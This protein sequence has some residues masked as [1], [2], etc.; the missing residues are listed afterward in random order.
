MRWMLITLTSLTPAAAF[1]Q[2]YYIAPAPVPAPTVYYVAP[3]PN[4][5]YVAPTQYYTP[6][7]S[8][9]PKTQIER[10]YFLSDRD[11][12]KPPTARYQSPKS[13]SRT[14]IREYYYVSPNSDLD[15]LEKEPLQELGPPE[16]LQKPEPQ[17]AIG[18]DAVVPEA[19]KS[20]PE[21]AIP[22][23]N[24]TEKPAE[25]KL[26]E[27]K[28]ADEKPAEAKAAEKPAEN[29]PIPESP[30]ET[31]PDGQDGSN[32]PSE[33]TTEEPAPEPAEPA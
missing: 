8:S 15:A 7:N 24:S 28:P 23:V 19:T 14:L 12:N 2:V 32:T 6:A 11:A 13:N 27:V 20:T 26:L 18:K 1:G 4:A 31:T 21:S 3:A 30:S 5:Y 10:Y 29:A 17:E 33:S 9:L 22:P 16:K 25:E